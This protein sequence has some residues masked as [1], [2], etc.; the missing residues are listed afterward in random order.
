MM[1]R[2]GRGKP[3]AVSEKKK[4]VR[5]TRKKKRDQKTASSRGNKIQ[6]K[7]TKTGRGGGRNSSRME[8]RRPDRAQKQELETV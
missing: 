7:T 3:D 2:R 6:G 4:T 5:R 8:K 1:V